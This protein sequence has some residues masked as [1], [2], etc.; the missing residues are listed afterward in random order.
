VEEAT[1]WFFESATAMPAGVELLLNP[2]A[3]F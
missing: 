1:E 3:L 2:P